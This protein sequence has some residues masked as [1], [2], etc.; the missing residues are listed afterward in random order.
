MPGKDRWLFA[1][2]YHQHG[3]KERNGKAKWYYDLD[4]DEMTSPMKGRVVISFNKPGRNVRLMA[5]NWVNQLIIQEILAEPLSIGEFPGFKAVHL[6]KG[7]LDV[8]V[9]QSLESWRTA[10]QNV[11]GVYLI[12]DKSDGRLYVGSACGEGGIWQRW[13]SYAM[14]GHGG[15]VELKNLLQEK[16]S[17]H[18]EN[19]C[20]SVLEIADIHASA[21]DILQRE[22][23]W[24]RVLHT[25]EHGHNRN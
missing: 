11:G 23:H 25:R 22:S 16:D 7:E 1:G 5:E 19:F 13:C 10:L 20:F 3:V 6:T 18:A 4:E 8:I 24:K 2:V 15:N 21:Q 14:T 17:G 12:A 9:R